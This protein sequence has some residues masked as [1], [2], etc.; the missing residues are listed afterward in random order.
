MLVTCGGILVAD[1]IAANLPKIS[2]PGELVFSEGG[3]EMHMGGHAG[4]VSVDLRK[5]GLKS[6]EVST[7]GPIGQ[8]VF[9]DFLENRLKEHGLV[10]HLQR[11]KDVGTSKNVVLVIS[12][13]DRR[14]H[15]DNGAN[16][17]LDPDFVMALLEE[18]KPL[19]FYLGGV[20]LTGILDEKLVDV[21]KKAKDLHCLTVLDPV[22]P[23]RHNWDFIL[24]SMKWTDVFHCNREEAA[25]ITGRSDPIEAA[26][27]LT[28]ENNLVIISHGEKGLVAETKNYLFELGVF[29]VPTVDPSGAGDALCAGIVHG[30]VNASRRKEHSI[31]DIAP[32]D[33]AGTLLGGEAAGA[34]CVTEVGT[35]TSV[36]R[37]KVDRILLDQKETVSRS[38]LRITPL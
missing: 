7:I 30:L 28:T 23:Y 31:S 6:G 35:T 16:W 13:E 27:R 5:L 38:R 26:R 17:F 34:A 24:P 11:V 14:Y 25:G 21:L 12:G 29:N 22:T 32:E 15:V 20:G 37:E 9:G 2:Q 18:E 1:I 4:N 19:I 33:L 36:T 8:D 10:T 3:I